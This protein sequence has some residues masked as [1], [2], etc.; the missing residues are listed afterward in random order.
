M[1]TNNVGMLLFNLERNEGLP[2]IFISVYFLCE[3]THAR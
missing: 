3:K 1:L 2:Y